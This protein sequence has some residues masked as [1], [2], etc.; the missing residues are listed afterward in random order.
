MVFL[1]SPCRETPK[2]VLKNKV[3]K[4]KVGWWVGWSEIQL[5]HGVDLSW[6]AA[7]GSGCQE[8]V[9]KYPGVRPRRISCL[10]GAPP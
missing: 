1:N 5:M 6:W 10:V 9:K 8:M 7:S 2:N 3:K 4:K